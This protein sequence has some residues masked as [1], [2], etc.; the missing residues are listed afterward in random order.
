MDKVLQRRSGGGGSVCGCR[1]GKWMRKSKSMYTPLGV[2]EVTDAF[3]YNKPLWNLDNSMI[4]NRCVH[5]GSARWWSLAQCYT[6]GE[7]RR[8]T[9]NVWL[10]DGDCEHPSDFCLIMEARN[11]VPLTVTMQ[12]GAYKTLFCL[13]L[14]TSRQFPSGVHEYFWLTCSSYPLNDKHLLPFTPK[15][16]RTVSPKPSQ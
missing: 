9:A 14:N 16:A 11:N 2:E 7:E 6:D 10:V 3:S 12:Y 5:A 1:Q 4:Q 15:L 13:P 8:P